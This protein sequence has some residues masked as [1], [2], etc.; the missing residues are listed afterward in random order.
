MLRIRNG[1]RSTGLSSVDWNAE[2]YAKYSFIYDGCE[3]WV[4]FAG[5]VIHLTGPD[6]ICC[7][8][9]VHSKT[10]DY[11]YVRPDPKCCTERALYVIHAFDSMWF[12]S[13]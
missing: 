6:V 5:D 11:I 2:L 10:I 3:Y 13:E 9:L 8:D 1:L 12:W 7:V 4:M